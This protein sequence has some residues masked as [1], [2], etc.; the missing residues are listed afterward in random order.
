MPA[1]FAIY[2]YHLCSNVNQLIKTNIRSNWYF[3]CF[4][5]IKIDNFVSDS[6]HLGTCE[7][8]REIYKQ[9]WFFNEFDTHMHD[10][11]FSLVK[12]WALVKRWFT[13]KLTF[14]L[15]LVIHYPECRG[16]WFVRVIYI[17]KRL[18]LADLADFEGELDWKG[19]GK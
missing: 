14:S 15:G 16:I 9:T 8:N 1:D 4:H 17:E 2:F 10:R 7:N 18:G 5:T 13:L 3:R 12:S 19:T 6:L 11:V